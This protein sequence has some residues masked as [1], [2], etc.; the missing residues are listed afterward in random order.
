MNLGHYVFEN[1]LLLSLSFNSC[2][3]ITCALNTIPYFSEALFV[4]HS[5]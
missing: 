2:A 5:S 3:L 4:F 1:S